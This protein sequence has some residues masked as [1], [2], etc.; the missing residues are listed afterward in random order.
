MTRSLC[1]ALGALWGCMCRSVPKTVKRQCTSFRSCCSANG[2]LWN[3]LN[4][5]FRKVELG[6]KAFLDIV[7]DPGPDNQEMMEEAMLESFFEEETMIGSFFECGSST[8]VCE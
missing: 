1:Y 5:S 8:K 3:R 2:K 4:I 6:D 7:D